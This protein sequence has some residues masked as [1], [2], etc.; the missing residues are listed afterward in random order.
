M[1]AE[2]GFATRQ[3][4]AWCCAALY[5]PAFD[6]FTDMRAGVVIRVEYRVCDVLNITSGH[7]WGA[8]TLGTTQVGQSR[9]AVAHSS[10]S[11]T[12]NYSS[13]QL[14]ADTIFI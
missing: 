13:L 14:T 5:C 8:G 3:P 10:A 11:G 9:Q 4:S 12:A 2:H 7:S 1:A 6:G